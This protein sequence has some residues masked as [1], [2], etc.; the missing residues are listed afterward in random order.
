MSLHKNDVDWTPI[1]HRQTDWQGD[2]YI[3]P[4][5]V[6]RAVTKRTLVRSTKRWWRFFFFFSLGHCMD[7]KLSVWSAWF[8]VYLFD[9]NFSNCFKTKFVVGNLHVGDESGL[10]GWWFY[11]GGG[12]FC[13]VCCR[14]HRWWNWGRISCGTVDVFEHPQYFSKIFSPNIISPGKLK[15]VWKHPQVW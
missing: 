7:I 3:S 15:L 14:F 9:L 1:L 8:L 4:N 13:L 2:S 12:T 6:C 10:V 5:F 11:S